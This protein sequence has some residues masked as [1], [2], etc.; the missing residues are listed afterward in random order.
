MWVRKIGRTG[1]A[2]SVILPP[3]IRRALGWRRGD[4]LNI[5]IVSQ[6]AI[7]MRKVPEQKLTDEIIAAAKPEATITYE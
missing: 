4:F 7:T 1:D 5:E 3:A 6:D 2:T